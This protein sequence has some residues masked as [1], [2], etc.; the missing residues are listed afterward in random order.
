MATFRQAQMLATA[1]RDAEALRGFEDVIAASD[2]PPG[3][4][5]IARFEGAEAALASD[6]E[7][8]ALELLGL[9]AADSAVG[10]FDRASAHWRAAEILRERSDPSWVEEAR[11]AIAL[12]PGGEASVDA[13]DALE[14]AEL[15][16]VPLAAAYV[17]Y[18][19]FDN[20]V[21]ADLYT[22]ITDG[23]FGNETIAEAWFFLGALAEHEFADAAA[24]E[25]YS[26]S[27]AFDADG[28][29]ADDSY[30]WL[31]RLLEADGQLVEAAET[32]DL[33]VDAF[34]GS[35]FA[36]DAALRG[37]ITKARVGFPDEAGTRLREIASTASPAAAS[38]AAGW[39]AALQL[40]V[41]GDPTA[42]A[43]DPSSVWALLE[44]A[45]D[46]ALAQI[47]ASQLAE[48]PRVATNAQVSHLADV[49]DWLIATYGVAPISGDEFAASNGSY[50][51]ARELTLVGEM[52]V[53]QSII[54]SLLQGRSD[55][56][57][58]LLAL[59]E[60]AAAA[61]LHDVALRAAS[62]LLSDQLPSE[63]LETPTAVERLAYPAPFTSD[64]L[65]AADAEGV[66]PLLLLA[67][68]RQ[69]SAFDPRAGS[70]A[71]A[72]GL[73][74]VIAPTGEQ[75]AISLGVDW[76]LALLGEPAS[77]LRFGA[78]YLAEQ[79][80]RFNGNALAALAAY[81]AGPGQAQR[82]LDL[83]EHPGA[84]GYL[85]AVDFTETRAYLERVIENWGWY[86]YL[87]AGTERP[88][89]R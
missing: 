82:W 70:S 57:A 60:A 87:Y 11:A 88:S 58:G 74:Q 27:I 4:I 17:R 2:L 51:L 9:L 76:D 42:A 85:L 30:W 1:G 56:P 32:Y 5:V 22:A 13:L 77:S 89:I 35:P 68:V 54:G 83:Q 34:P 61:G 62:L 45:G 79:L 26:A 8:R 16:V 48:R 37:A 73:T 63:R 86:R 81:N 78:H 15:D 44:L 29:L 10:A 55:D 66:P 67:L 50:N 40:Q 31:A 80:E 47:P 53:A 23:P 36:G 21:A 38:E 64:L 33:L 39:L 52:P 25:A 14:R 49:A 28:W 12:A 75:I 43:A 18:R 41:P 20:T 72:Y 3:L 19:T 69:E 6:D 7:V 84:E 65:A 71:G 59:A 24:I 46:D